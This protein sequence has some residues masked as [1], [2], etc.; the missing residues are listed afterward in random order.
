MIMTAITKTT[1]TTTKTMMMMMMHDN[2]DN[3]A[4]GVLQLLSLLSLLLLLIL[5]P[6][7]IL[8]LNKPV[9]SSTSTFTLHSDVTL[10]NDTTIQKV[11]KVYYTTFFVKY[12]TQRLGSQVV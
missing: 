11:F 5:L 6:L 2:G 1:T 12:N 3:D 8:L 10:A 7:P 4:N 9:L